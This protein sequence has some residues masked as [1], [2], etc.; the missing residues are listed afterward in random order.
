[1]SITPGQRTKHPESTSRQYQLVERA[2][3]LGWPAARV[4]VIDEDLAKSGAQAEQR[5]GFQ[6]L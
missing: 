5:F 6:H 3:A 4:Q 2:V 1:M